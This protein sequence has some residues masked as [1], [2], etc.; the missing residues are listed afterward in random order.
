M[1]CRA[2]FPGNGTTENSPKSPAIVQCQT[3]QADAKIEL[4]RVFWRTGKVRKPFGWPSLQ[5]QKHPFVHNSVSSQ[6][7]VQYLRG[8]VRNFGGV[9]ALL[10]VVLWIQIQEDIHQFC[11]VG[12]GEG[13]GAPKLW[14]RIL[15]T[16]PCFLKMLVV[17]NVGC[18]SLVRL[19]CEKDQKG[20]P[21]KWYPWKG[22]IFPTPGHWN[23]SFYES[24]NFLLKSPWSWTT[25]RPKQLYAHI[26]IYIYFFFAWAGTTESA[27]NSLT[28][29]KFRQTYFW[30]CKS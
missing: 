11:W 2:L 27:T 25:F 30:I 9:F 21:Q 5:I 20:Y 1:T 16:N 22:R 14:A 29:M 4:A 26:Y 28:Q 10:L 23:C 7:W 8:F 13:R 24:F 12:T 3:L 15:W 17:A 18:A 19:D 6:F